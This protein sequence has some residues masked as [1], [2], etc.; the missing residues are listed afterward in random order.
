MGTKCTAIHLNES[1]LGG[2]LTK[3]PFSVRGRQLAP[4]PGGGRLRLQGFKPA[5]V[6]SAVRG[7]FKTD[8]CARDE[9]M[10]LILRRRAEIQ[11]HSSGS[12][13]LRKLSRR[14]LRGRNNVGGS[15]KHSLNEHFVDRRVQIGG[16]IA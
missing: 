12:P 6:T 3:D 16:R 15:G 13:L 14:Q 1:A 10:T 4:V 8:S 11:Q 2:R 5:V 7:V 9:A